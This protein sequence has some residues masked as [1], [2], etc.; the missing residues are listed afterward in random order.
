MEKI[1][2][3]LWNDPLTGLTGIQNIYKKAKKIDKNIT[4]KLVKD[5]LDKQYS[6]QL[7]KKFVKPRNYYP[8]T[9]LYENEIIQIDLMDMK[10]IST[11]NKNYNWLFVCVDVY[12]RKGYIFPMKNKST[13][14]IIE[15]FNK[16]LLKIYI[17]F[18]YTH[19]HIQTTNNKFYF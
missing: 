6:A 10:D 1:I 15:S 13:K 16:L 3:N 12:T 8:I 9:A 11:K 17:L 14:S 7:H 5:I 18:L 19:P 4:L 2:L